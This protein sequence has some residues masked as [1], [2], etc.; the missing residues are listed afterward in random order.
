[1]NFQERI[2]KRLLPILLSVAMVFTMLPMTVAA[3]GEADDPVKVLIFCNNG[4]F[5]KEFVFDPV[6]ELYDNMTINNKSI[7]ATVSTDK[8]C[9][10][11]DL[12]QYSLIILAMLPESVDS[13]ANKLLEYTKSGG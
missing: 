6:K 8:T 10:D 7:T 12:A 3:E 5:P 9:L 11:A 4:N 13:Y 2:K 1:M